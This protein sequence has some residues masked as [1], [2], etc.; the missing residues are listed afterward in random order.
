VGDRFK[1]PKPKGGARLAPP[2]VAPAP[3]SSLHRRPKFSLEHLSKSHCIS[4]CSNDEKA[5]FADRLHELSQI[6]WQVIQ[7]AHRHGQGHEKIARDVIKVAI[8][9]VITEDVQIIAFRCIGKAPMVGFK[10]DETFYVVWIDRAFDL[11]P[12]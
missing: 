1:P 10:V 6:T 8:P 5:A 4:A 12:H 2:P 3:A 7:G 11:Y 9:A